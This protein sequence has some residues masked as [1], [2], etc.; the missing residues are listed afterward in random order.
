[1]ASPT[2]HASRLLQLFFMW[3]SAG[4]SESGGHF[5]QLVSTSALSMK[6][7]PAL[8]VA[9]G[10]HC[11]LELYS[12]C[13]VP[14]GHGM[15]N[16]AMTLSTH[17][18]PAEQCGGFTLRWRRVSGSD[19][20]DVTASRRIAARFIVWVGTQKKTSYQQ[21]TSLSVWD[22]FS[23]VWVLDVCM[24]VLDEVAAFV[25]SLENRRGLGKGRERG[26]KRRWWVREIKK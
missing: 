26:C 14:V 7:C 23:G 2:G 6:Y 5:S 3:F 1:M 10:L 22:D 11:N 15:Q 17:S 19:T 13:H 9:F 18:N 16:V 20:A 8:H 25:E 4:C 21:D 12:L 24:K